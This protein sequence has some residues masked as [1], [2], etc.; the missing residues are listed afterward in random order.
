MHERRVSDAALRCQPARRATSVRR[1]VRVSL[2][3]LSIVALA[4]GPGIVAFAGA[5]SWVLALVDGFVLVTIGGIALIHILPHALLSCGIWAFVGAGIGLLL[6]SLAHGRD[7]HGARGADT[8]KARP[9][10]ALALLGIA[11][12]AFLD[13]SAFTEHGDAHEHGP[14][15]L[16]LAVVL[17]RIPEGLAIWW[18]AR[19][20]RGGA[21]SAVLALA[22]VAVA[23]VLGAHFGGELV[24]GARASVFSFVQAIVAGSLLHVIVHHAPASLDR[25]KGRETHDAH[26]AHHPHDAHGGRGLQLAPALGALGG[27]ALLVV[28]SSSHPTAQRIAHEIGMGPT[29]VT[30]A[31]ESAPALLVAYLASGLLHAFLPQSLALWLSSGGALSQSLR[32]LLVGP[33]LQSGS[34]AEPPFYRSMLERG[35]SRAAVLTVL[36]AAPELGL[37]TMLV[38]WSL[39]GGT[40]TVVRGAAALLTAAVVGYGVTLLGRRKDA[41]APPAVVPEGTLSCRLRL[42]SAVRYGLGDVVDRSTPW[43]LL[44]LAVA[45]FAEPLLDGEVVSHVPSWIEVPV[46]AVLGVPIYLCASSATPLVAVL[47][48]KGISPGAAIAF[49]LTGPVINVSTFG[50]LRGLHG[51]RVATLFTAAMVVVPTVLGAA[52]NVGLP[53]DRPEMFHAVAHAPATAI[54]IVSLTV[55]VVLVAISLLRHGPRQMISQLVTTSHEH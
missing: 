16:G 9:A 42:W 5:R 12:H 37:A 50:V 18:L 43:I 44:G 24:H 46:F 31:L 38:S 55:L 22:L 20:R 45:A 40:L 29:F 4:L 2:L 49:L 27:V 35:A 7:D 6:P 32:G 36:V 39:L 34:R 33:L 19:P 8:S 54:E 30:L 51:R 3:V 13:G 21:M 11:M 26:D 48:H 17:H 25:P 47:L 23:T 1:L 14:E 10:M 28:V 41:A 53:R 52:V 15:L